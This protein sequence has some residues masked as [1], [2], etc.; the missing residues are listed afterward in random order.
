MPNL[1]SSSPLGEYARGPF[2]LNVVQIYTRGKMSEYALPFAVSANRQRVAFVAT[3]K[4]FGAYSMDFWIGLVNKMITGRVKK[5]P[6]LFEPNGVFMVNLWDNE[7]GFRCLTENFRGSIASLVF[8]ADGN[9]LAIEPDEA[10]FRYWDLTVADTPVM[11][12]P[13][14]PWGRHHSY[15]VKF[16]SENLITL[17]GTFILIWDPVKNSSIFDMSERGSLT[18]GDKVICARSALDDS[19]TVIDTEAR[20]TYPIGATTRLHITRGT[21]VADHADGNVRAWEAGRAGF[22]TPGKLVAA[23]G[24][25][26]AVSYRKALCSFDI[27]SGLDVCGPVT[28]CLQ[29]AIAGNG[30]LA[31]RL[32]SSP[33]VVE[34]RSPEGPRRRVEIPPTARWFSFTEDGSLVATL[35]D[36]THKDLGPCL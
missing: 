24:Q 6:P 31:V 10:A 35:S 11:V 26:I 22:A 7:H 28:D 25:A 17:Q 15:A 1:G 32:A 2:F 27:S 18:L 30:W 14:T 23:M 3:S 29:A 16:T 5:C 33:N 20:C 12:T 21:V 34:I 4:F 8:S 9:Y 13:P 36:N 19:T